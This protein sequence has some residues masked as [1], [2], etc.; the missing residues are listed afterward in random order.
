MTANVQRATEARHEIANLLHTYTEIADRKDVDAV[1]DILGDAVVR[2]PTDGYDTRDEAA[3][4]FGRLWAGDTPHRHDVSNLVVHPDGQGGWAAT[5]H[6]TR[7]VLSPEPVLATLGEYSL[8][9][10]QDEA[11]WTVSHL[12]VTRTWSR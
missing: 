11:E 5:A 12:T 4:F 1:L 6:Y 2:F 8:I 10:R 3:A 7:Y 9:V